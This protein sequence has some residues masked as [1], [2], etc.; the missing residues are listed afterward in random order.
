M[1]H[2]QD[3]IAR[4]P[5]HVPVNFSPDGTQSLHQLLVR[6]LNTYLLENLKAGL[7]D[8]LKFS[9]AQ[10]F[11]AR[12]DILH[13]LP[14]RDEARVCPQQE[15]VW[16]LYRSPRKIDRTHSTTAPVSRYVVCSLINTA[17]GAETCNRR[18]SSG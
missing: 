5:N 11:D 8:T 13:F 16:S 14:C 2:P 1:Q 17:A 3:H 6:Y 4:K 9:L 7:M 15:H 12:A 10:D 18:I